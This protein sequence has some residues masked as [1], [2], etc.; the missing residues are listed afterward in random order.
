MSKILNLKRC[1]LFFIWFV[2]SI[3]LISVYAGILFI[4]QAYIYQAYRQMIPNILGAQ[5]EKIDTLIQVQTN[6]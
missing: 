4:Y 5:T 2:H 6:T 1:Q 3:V